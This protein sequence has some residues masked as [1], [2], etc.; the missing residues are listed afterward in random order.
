M[1][2]ELQGLGRTVLQGLG[3]RRHHMQSSI[4]HAYET[5]TWQSEVQTPHSKTTIGPPQATKSDLAL[6]PWKQK[7][8]D[9]ESRVEPTGPG[10]SLLIRIKTKPSKKWLK[11]QVLELAPVQESRWLNDFCLPS[12]DTMGT[13]EIWLTMLACPPKGTTVPLLPLPSKCQLGQKSNMQI[14]SLI[15][16]KKF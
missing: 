10:K 4:L 16:N 1:Q 8:K 13:N 2:G 6:Q 7:E 15:F 3:L 11:F 5:S 14:Q 12:R 9:Q